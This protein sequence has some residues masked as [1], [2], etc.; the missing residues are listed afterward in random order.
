MGRLVPKCS[1]PILTSPAPPL[2]A[3]MISAPFSTAQP[4]PLPQPRSHCGIGHN[5]SV[6]IP[7]ALGESE[8]KGTPSR[9]Q[10]LPSESERLP[11]W[12]RPRVP[13]YT[14]HTSGATGNIAGISVW[15]WVGM[16][17]GLLGIDPSFLLGST[18]YI[19]C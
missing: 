16:Q 18:L 15:G 9:A 13:E 8:W 6:R 11:L 19:P 12:Q 5:G 3:I 2:A 1:Y 14:G 10:A 17:G 7:G 4:G